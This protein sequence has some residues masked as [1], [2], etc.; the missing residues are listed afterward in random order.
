METTLALLMGTEISA[1]APQ[2]PRARLLRRKLRAIVP[3]EEQVRPKNIF[4]SNQNILS[5]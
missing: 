1:A 3:I 4:R 2:C 5:A